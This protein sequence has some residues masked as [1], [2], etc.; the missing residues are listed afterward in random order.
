MIG[1]RIPPLELH[2]G[3]KSAAGLAE[4]NDEGECHGTSLLLT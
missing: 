2:F 3:T 4:K 1:F